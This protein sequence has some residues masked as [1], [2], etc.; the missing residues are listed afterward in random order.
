MLPVKC[1][2]GERTAHREIARSVRAFIVTTTTPKGAEIPAGQY[3]HDTALAA[4]APD[5]SV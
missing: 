5:E 4:E 3:D 2:C 1:Q